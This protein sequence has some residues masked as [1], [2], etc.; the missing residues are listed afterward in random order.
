METPG[1]AG[2]KD[3]VCALHWIHD[4]ISF[5]KG[6]PENVTVFGTGSGGAIAHLLTFSPL[7]T[8]L[9]HKVIVQTGCALS[10][11]VF[12]PRIDSKVASLCGYK[13]VSQSMDVYNFLKTLPTD[14]LVEAQSAIFNDEV[15]F[16]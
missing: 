9:F 4:N 11:W 7:A 5:F 6:D 16:I 13:G 10:P 15:S 2:L 14:K 12:V 1:N 8:G 3:V